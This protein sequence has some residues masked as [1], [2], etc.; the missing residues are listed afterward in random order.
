[1]M[2]TMDDLKNR[3]RAEPAQIR[4]ALR[5]A[6]VRS[7]GE[8]RWKKYDAEAAERAILAYG[9]KGRKARRPVGMALSV[10]TPEGWSADKQQAAYLALT[11]AAAPE[12]AS[13]AP[14]SLTERLH[15]LESRLAALENR[16]GS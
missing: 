14:E 16:V 8:K 11:A 5:K 9:I 4:R 12:Q 1:M 13:A 2:L 15:K 6:A 7:E 10:W 3:F